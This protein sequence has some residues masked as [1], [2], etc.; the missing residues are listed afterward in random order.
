MRPYFAIASLILSLIAPSGVGAESPTGLPA[1]KARLATETAVVQRF[2]APSAPPKPAMLVGEID[3]T[4]GGVVCLFTD[5]RRVARPASADPGPLKATLF[6]EDAAEKADL[7]WEANAPF[8]PWPEALAAADG[9]GFL[10]ETADMAAAV[11]V[12]VRVLGARPEAPAAR[13]VQLAEAGCDAQALDMLAA[14]V[15]E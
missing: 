11:T 12:R 13:L 6:R 3:L 8:A 2:R 5:Q 4:A 7:A 9:Q 14:G 10:V 1:L 15:T